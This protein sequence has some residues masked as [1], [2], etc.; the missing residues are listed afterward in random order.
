MGLKQGVVG[1]IAEIA[2]SR[3]GLPR[4]EPQLLERTRNSAGVLCIR[5]ATS[6]NS[7]LR[8][9]FLKRVLMRNISLYEVQIAA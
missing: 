7:L 4:W 6:W 8:A 3:K 9:R 2:G 5:L 1:L